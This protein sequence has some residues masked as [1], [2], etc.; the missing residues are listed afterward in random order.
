MIRHLTLLG[1]C[2]VAAP[3]A[4]QAPR[5]TLRA[6]NTL[7]I[8]RVD[9][10]IA[11]PWSAVRQRLAA[12]T[13]EHV[14]V[15]DAAGR[16]LTSQVVDDDGDGTSDE[17][18]FQGTF[19]PNETKDFTVEAAAPTAKPKVKTFARHDDPRDDVAWE[20]D[21]IAWR[22]Y[23]EGLKKTSSAMSSNGIDI[24]VKKTRE[25][26]VEKWYGKGHD[27]YHVDT[28][29]GADFYDVGETLGAGGIGVWRGDS[30]YRADNFKAWKI[31]ANGPLRTIFELR[32]DPYDAAGQR[33]SEVKR[34]TQDAG[35]N[36]FKQESTL[37]SAD[38]SDITYA[39]GLFKQPAAVGIESKAQPLAWLT[40]WA[41]VV[42]KSGGHGELGAAVL[43]EK[44]R[45]VDWK[46]TG[47]HYLAILKARS[48]VPVTNYVA[49]GWTDSGDFRDVK[50][51]W[52]YLDAAAQRIASPIRVTLGGASAA[53][54]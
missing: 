16:E 14:R 39:T 32:Y 26:I 24:W 34:V 29:E 3:L 47:N 44:N 21:R 9:E 38:G 28:G 51:W 48:G 37:R 23:G 42:P 49:A 6:E 52:K 4:A 53:A 20:S 13:P 33:V 5:A 27:S 36:W 1:A 15:L 54:R 11:V 45:L 40:A 46:E 25:P 41:P 50:D 8:T 30:L 2:A 18:L 17:L 19:W 35:Q 43:V 31:V 22:V 10:M 12:A 7:G